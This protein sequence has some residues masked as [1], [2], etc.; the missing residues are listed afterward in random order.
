MLER[1]GRVWRIVGPFREE[2]RGERYEGDEEDDVASK[3]S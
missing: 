2:G 1:A 3:S